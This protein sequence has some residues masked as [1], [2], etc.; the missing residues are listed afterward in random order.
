MGDIPEEVCNEVPA[1]VTRI[2]DEE[3]C[4]NVPS[5]KCLPTFKEECEEVLEQVPRQTYE[6]K[7]RTEYIQECSQAPAQG[8]RA[9]PASVTAYASRQPLTS[10]P[11]Y[12]SR[13]VPAY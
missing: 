13:P 6:T 2:I 7:C 10:A 5:R 4:S 9:A 12:E 3:Q 11:A 8:F 1:S